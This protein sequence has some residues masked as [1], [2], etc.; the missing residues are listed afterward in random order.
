MD[1]QSDNTEDNSEYKTEEQSEDVKDWAFMNSTA[2]QQS[3]QCATTSIVH[4]NYPYVCEI[5]KNLENQMDMVILVVCVPSGAQDVKM[6][7]NDEGVTATIKYKWSKVICNMEDLFKKPLATNQVTVD[8]PKIL[9]I[10]AALQ[11][12]TNGIDNVPESEIQVRL[13]IKVQTAPETWTKRGVSRDDGSQI[14]VAEF[15]GYVKGYKTKLCD[16]SVLF[17]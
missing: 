5:Y 11:N 9:S 13:P 17:E 16:S 8:H 6:E 4:S 3:F 2:S 14:V 10:N 12:L 1:E 7:L 15:L